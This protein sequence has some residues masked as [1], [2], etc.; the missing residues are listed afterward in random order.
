MGKIDLLETL[1]PKKSAKRR[2]DV[3]FA[4]AVPIGVLGGL[5]GLGGAEFRL[6]VLAGPLGYS[7]RRAVP[8]N[9]AVSLITLT[10]ALVSRST[11]LSFQPLLPFSSAI[12]SLIGGAVVVAFFGTALAKRLSNERLHWTHFGPA[13]GHWWPISSR[14]LHPYWDTGPRSGFDFVASMCRCAVRPPD[15]VGQQLARCGGRG[16]DYSH[17]SLRIRCRHQDRRHG[18]P[19]HQPAHCV[20]RIDP[21]RS[22]GCVL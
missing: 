1:P 22:S 8:L 12:L 18:Q 11:T 21:L 9:L 15:R 14:G 16:I 2:A 4:Y 20:G 7:A 19:P 13:P 6:P 17:A 3:A 5:I 10:A